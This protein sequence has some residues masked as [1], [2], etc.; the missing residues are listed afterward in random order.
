MGACL[1]GTLVGNWE[2]TWSHCGCGGG[3]P[4][5]DGTWVGTWE[6]T[7]LHCGVQVL[8]APCQ[9]VGMVDVVMVLM[10]RN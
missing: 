1:G 5:W 8:E 4:G 7:W 9:V 3:E 6:G 10:S 2:G